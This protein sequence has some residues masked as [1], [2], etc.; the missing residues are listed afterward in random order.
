MCDHTTPTIVKNF[1]DDAG[2]VLVTGYVECSVYRFRTDY[3]NCGC[4]YESEFDCD[5]DRNSW[6]RWR[7]C[8][9]HED[10]Q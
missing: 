7:S 1:V 2:S 6:T 8:E 3:M 10:S 9:K 5:A 4:V